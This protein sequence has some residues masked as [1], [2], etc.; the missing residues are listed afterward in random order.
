M[1]K[2]VLDLTNCRYPLEMHGRF[3]KALGFPEYY[4]NNWD[5]FWDCLTADCSVSF[6]EVRGG[7]AVAEELRPMVETLR[8]LLEE[9][10]RKSADEGWVLDYVFRE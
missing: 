1:M 5:A 9:A 7:N 4:G 3:R 8:R 6:V 10:K 2:A